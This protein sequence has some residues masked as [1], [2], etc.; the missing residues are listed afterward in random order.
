MDEAGEQTPVPVSD[1]AGAAPDQSIVSRVRSA[2]ASPP[3]QRGLSWLIPLA[4][5]AA[6]SAFLYSRVLSRPTAQVPGGA[7]GVIYVWFFEAVEHA[8]ANLHN[9]LISHAMNAPAGVST[10]WNAAA[11]LPAIVLAPMTA[12]IGPVAT[13]GLAM[14]VCPV[15]AAFTAYFAFRRITGKA[16]GSFLGATLYGFGP[17]FVGQ[18]G[19]L[20]L[21]AAAA[22]L[23]LILLVAYRI[24]VTQRG[25]PVW[26]GVWLGLLTAA[27][28]LT[29]EEV[30][31][32]VAAASL[33]GLLWLV[34]LGRAQVQARFRYAVSAVGVGA[35]TAIVLVA[36]PLW[37][38]LYGPLALHGLITHRAALDI[39]SFVRPSSLQYF[40]TAADRAA[41][42]N[43]F[44]GG[45]ENTGYLGIPVLILIV[46]LLVW[47]TVE[48]DRFALWWVV[49]TAVVWS[50][51]LGSP[52]WVNGHRTGIP[53][54]WSLF[55]HIKAL[56]NVVAPRFS[57][58]VALLL[59]L[60]IAWGLARASGRAYLAMTAATAVALVSLLP[61]GRY[62]GLTNFSTPAFFTGRGAQRIPA[63][64][65]VLVLPNAA[66]PN[67]A[68]RLMF[69]QVKAHLRFNIIGG[70]GI[71]N[72]N[73]NWSYF[74]HVPRF[75]E[76]LNYAGQTGIVPGPVKLTAADE[77]LR[78]SE[79]SYIVITN[80]LPYPRSATRAA[81]YLTGC[82]PEHVTD[83]I[84]C[85]VPRP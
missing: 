29:A 32:M 82:R 30:V 18:H 22:L 60:L 84:I 79:T 21:I 78:K 23:P 50:F 41:N 35:G 58:L 57:L 85:A 81:T 31:V 59:G 38:Q 67:R 6:A 73:G 28:V 1:E 49:A 48:H 68:A 14:V 34:V 8:L 39:A 69:W 51:S 71:F 7:D 3:T 16:A 66:G 15:L 9:P 40:S 62:G 61:A 37:F 2:W 36:Y 83:V 77:S 74:A 76:M 33:V 17:F 24:F 75:A 13:V 43:F 72:D 56:K 5:W 47:L 70:Y 10:M 65:T 45:P 26:A 44:S 20:H 11:L 63:N 54:T 53:G 42:G 55:T 46:G 12:A 52:L 80:Q 27:L 19:H 64:S 4:C 25:S